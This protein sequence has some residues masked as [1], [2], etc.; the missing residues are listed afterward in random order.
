LPSRRRHD[1]G[2]REGEGVDAG[3]AREELPGA[4]R[5]R[6][7]EPVWTGWPVFGPRGWRERGGGENEKDETGPRE[8]PDHPVHS[9]EEPRRAGMFRD[10]RG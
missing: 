2:R 3:S 7:G 8:R 5:G 4:A 6:S 10:R 9:R 1:V